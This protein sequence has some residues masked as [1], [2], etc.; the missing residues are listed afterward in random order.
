M[1]N[2][3][4]RLIYVLLHITPIKKYRTWISEQKKIFQKFK[5]NDAKVIWI[6]CASL[7]E[8]E[9]IKAFIPKL[10]EINP[11]INI[12]FFSASGYV[13]FKDFDLI[14]QIFH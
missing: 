4:L 5:K 12:T 2:L 1:Y 9:Q 11:I 6:H 13:N 3:I 14:S 8:Y 7:G 10:K